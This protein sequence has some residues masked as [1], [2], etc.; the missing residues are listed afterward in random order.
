MRLSLEKLWELI[1]T[2]LQQ[3]ETEIEDDEEGQPLYH[4]GWADAMR[5][6]IEILEPELYSC[7]QTEDTDE[8]W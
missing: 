8:E 1:D 5:W 7:S 2:K 3:H 6:L 4:E